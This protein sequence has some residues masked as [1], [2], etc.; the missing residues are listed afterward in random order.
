MSI[1]AI[2]PLQ[3]QQLVQNLEPRRRLDKAKPADRNAGP[4]TVSIS[5]AAL[6]LS[7]AERTEAA[8]P[9]PQA[10]APPSAGDIAS[11]PFGLL[12]TTG[13]SATGAANGPG[14]SAALTGDFADVAIGRS[15]FNKILRQELIKAISSD[16]R[17]AGQT[18]GLF[19]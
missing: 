8:L 15:A 1:S 6:A 17:F 3:G 14:S 12:S 2:R 11:L 19:V 16:P 4:D 10:E 5:P 7:K 9:A 13:S 18:P